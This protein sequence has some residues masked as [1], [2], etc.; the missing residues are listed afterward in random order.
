MKRKKGIALVGL[1][2]SLLVL[3]SCSPEKTETIHSENSYTQVGSYHIFRTTEVE[4][5]LSFMEDFDETKFEIIDI[6]ASMHITS[7]GSDEF[8]IVTYKQISE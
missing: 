2:I 7:Y 5:Y 4:K 1:L 8:Y 3:C 6:S